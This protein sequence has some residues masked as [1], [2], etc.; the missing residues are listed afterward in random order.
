MNNATIW[1]VVFSAA[2]AI[3]TICVV[4]VYWLKQSFSHANRSFE[5]KV[6]IS[7]RNVAKE[8]S[9]LQRVQLPSYNLISQVSDDYYV[10]NI[11]DAIDAANL[12]YYLLKEFEQVSLN[13]D[14]EYGIYD[15]DTEQ[16]VYG[17][18]VSASGQKQKP[19][20]QGLATHSD[21]VYYFGVRFPDRRGYILSN[22]WIPI[23]FTLL[24][25]IAALFF[26]YATFEILRQKK[27]SELQK[28]FVNN[29]THEF[30]TPLSSIKVSAE[31]MLERS[32]PDSK[33]SNYL[34]IIRD[35][36]NHLSSQVERVLQIADLRSRKIQLNLETFDL[37]ELILESCEGMGS[38]MKDHKAT[39]VYQLF[40]KDPIV[41]ADK[42]H[43]SNVLTNLLD[44]ALKYSATDPILTITTAEDGRHRV[45]KIQDNGI[46][47]DSDQLKHIEKQFYRV[48]TGNVHNVKG[49]GLGLYYV[50]QIVEA[51]GWKMDIISNKGHGT[52][53]QILIPG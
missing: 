41:S 49:F 8:L 32:R 22:E 44:N 20:G 14:F 4:Q 43:L 16:M 24:L 48:S 45:I 17:N 34:R 6:H 1:R 9:D 21:L 13:T 7:L 2:L 15:C 12:E 29:L 36:A 19:K 31:V 23:S 27:L 30:K 35:Q 11:R 42:L 26:V 52:V 47:I 46:G 25:I 28:D 10:V 5:E 37:H 50:R 39:L 53:V 40:A 18:Y 38:I 51:H 33:M 3:I